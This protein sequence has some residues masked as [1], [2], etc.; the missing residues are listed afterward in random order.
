MVWWLGEKIR[1][2]GSRGQRFVC[3]GGAKWYQLCMLQRRKQA[4][5][6]AVALSRGKHHQGVW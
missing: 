5:L 6:T 4:C 3:T 1:G 2:L